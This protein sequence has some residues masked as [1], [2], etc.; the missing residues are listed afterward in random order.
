[1]SERTKKILVLV[2]FFLGIVAIG[3][4]LYFTVVGFRREPVEPTVT[5]PEG[6]PGQFPSSGEGAPVVTPPGGAPGILEPADEIA[7]GGITQ[8]TTLTTS[9]IES[10]AGRSDGRVNFYNPED[11]RFYTID[12]EGNV[13]TLSNQQF[14]AAESVVWN[15]GA[16]KAVIEFPDGSNIVYNFSTQQQVTLPQHWEDFDF[17]PST[18]EIIAK[19]LAVDPNNRWIVITNDDGSNAKSI[20]PLGLNES[21]VDVNWS[22]N[23]QV[24]AFA[25]TADPIIGGLDRKMIL[26][27]GKNDEN[28][29]GLIVEGL[30]FDSLWSP[31][32]STLAYSVYGDFSNGNPSLWTVSATPGT[33]GE[34]RRSLGLN[35]WIDKCTY[36]GATRLICAVP[37]N[38]G[39]NAGYSRTTFQNLPDH[40]YEVDLLTGRSTRIAIPDESTT[41][42]SLSVSSDGAQLYF[43]NERT[44]RLELIRL[45]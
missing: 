14:P 22:P 25:D 23:D 30:G 15:N 19:S 37:V 39:P 13:V 16:S 9:V 32:G 20:A 36:A 41:M 5:P 11:G 45:R 35:T 27:V 44:G 1:M 29:K 3:V 31:D 24:I 7:G 28:Y 2:G 34:N 38:L 42:S 10:A 6:A 40:V 8:V 18:D 17:S 33:M 43:K 4:I 26:P 21:K 12:A